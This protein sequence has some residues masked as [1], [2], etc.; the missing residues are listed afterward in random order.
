MGHSILFYLPSQGEGWP[1]VAIFLFLARGG[2]LLESFLTPGF[3]S[4][5]FMN[6]GCNVPMLNF[7]LLTP[8]YFSWCMAGLPGAVWLGLSCWLFPPW[9]CASFCCTSQRCKQHWFKKML[10]V[11]CPMLRGHLSSFWGT[12][13][14]PVVCDVM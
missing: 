6:Q 7:S 9:N 3:A 10:P 2:F 1:G 12:G 5:L 13:V 14:V 4:G 8:S 11:S